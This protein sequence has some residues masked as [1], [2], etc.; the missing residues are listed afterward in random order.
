MNLYAFKKN[1]IEYKARYRI[2]KGKVTALRITKIHNSNSEI[3]PSLLFSDDEKRKFLRV[4]QLH[5][6]K[7]LG[8]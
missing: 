7:Y 2:H 3:E 6:L 4:L 8:C 5:S 1:E